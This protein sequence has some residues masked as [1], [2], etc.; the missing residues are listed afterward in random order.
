MGELVWLGPMGKDDTSRKAIDVLQYAIS[1]ACKE[2][3]FRLYYPQ[4]L[5]AENW[6][7]KLINKIRS[8][9]G[10][11]CDLSG[12]RFNVYFEFGFAYALNI[13]RILICHKDSAGDIPADFK[14]IQYHIYSTMNEAESIIKKWLEAISAPNDTLSKITDT[15]PHPFQILEGDGHHE[16]SYDPLPHKKTFIFEDV[17]EPVTLQSILKSR[18]EA[19]EIMLKLHDLQ[20]KIAKITSRPFFQSELLGYVQHTPLRDESGTYFDA[21]IGVRHTDYYTFTA[22]HYPFEAL[23]DASDLSLIDAKTAHSLKEKISNLIASSS[24]PFVSP[25]TAMVFL[26][27]ELNGI[28][29]V[30]FQRRDTHKNFHARYPIQATAGGMIHPSRVIDQ[31]GSPSYSPVIAFLHELCEEAGISTSRKDVKILGFVK[32]TQWRECAFV[33]YVTADKKILDDRKLPIDTF[34]SEKFEPV[35]L[36]PHFITEYLRGA[37][38]GKGL[39]PLTLAALSLLLIHEFGLSIMVRIFKDASQ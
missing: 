9:N 4:V 26:V 30:Y 8:A 19:G 14:N 12:G 24:W 17:D 13:P 37:Q 31:D 11:I 25:L 7:E 36:Q 29:N 35:Q 21:K 33:G 18:P 20:D 39:S 2:F 28:K 27:S 23:D 3:G 15:L 38:G 16:Y 6:L 32:E 10:V 22:A 34:E 1:P 5:E